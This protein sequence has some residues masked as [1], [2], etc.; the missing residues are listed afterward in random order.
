MAVVT[1]WWFPAPDGA[2]DAL[3]RLHDHHSALLDAAVVAWFADEA[4]PEVRRP[5]RVVGDAVLAGAFW[6][7]VTG[8]PLLAPVLGSVVG[9]AVGLLVACLTRPGLA[10]DVVRECRRHVTRG[11][12]V[13]VLLTADEVGEPVLDRLAE[14]G[15]RFA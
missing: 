3:E 8:L 12:S 10:D 11:S 7:L 5:G 1:T 15:A 4:L 14:A 13:L 6:G 9:A 2:E